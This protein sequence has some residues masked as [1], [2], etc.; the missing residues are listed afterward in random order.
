MSRIIYPFEAYYFAFELYHDDKILICCY[1]SNKIIFEI[2]DNRIEIYNFSDT[3]RFFKL[4][5]S[6]EH[7]SKATVMNYRD[8]TT[9][10]FKTFNELTDY[11]ITD[12]LNEVIDILKTLT[13]IK[14]Q[15]MYEA[16]KYLFP[17]HDNSIKLVF[18]D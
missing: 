12:K 10:N 5:H 17:E 3:M 6:L 8:S 14:S 9:Y 16:L 2:Y 15:K 4:L 13:D 18:V 11:A 7:F 1:D